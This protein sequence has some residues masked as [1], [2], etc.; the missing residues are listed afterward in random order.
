MLIIFLHTSV[1]FR[2]FLMN[3]DYDF[4]DNLDLLLI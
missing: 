4:W 3:C 1:G 2:V